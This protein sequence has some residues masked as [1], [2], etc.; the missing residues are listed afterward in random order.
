M[1][2]PRAELCAELRPVASPSGEGDILC[3][4]FGVDSSVLEF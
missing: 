4:L 2:A 3:A 1:K